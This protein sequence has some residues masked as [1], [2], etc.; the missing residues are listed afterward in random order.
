MGLLLSAC[1]GSA[2]SD[3]QRFQGE[4]CREAI[5]GP[6]EEAIRR[7]YLGKENLKIDWPGV[8]IYER[9]T[10]QSGMFRGEVTHH[11]MVRFE[12]SWGYND[13]I[14]GTV[15]SEDCAVLLVDGRRPS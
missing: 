9:E 15:R 10:T 14:I 8:E 1:A 12:D 13:F 11:F 2:Y 4:H 6:A 5:K 7:K 3:E